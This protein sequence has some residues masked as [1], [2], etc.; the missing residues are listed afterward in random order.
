[1]EGGIVSQDGLTRRRLLQGGA[2]ALAVAVIDLHSWVP[3]FASSINSAPAYLQRSSYTPLLGQNF[4]ANIEGQAQTLKLLSISDV[5]RTGLVGAND[6]FVLELSG[7]LGKSIEQGIHTLK[8]PTLGTFNLFLT[9]VDQ[10]RSAQNYAIV[11]DRSVAIGDTEVP[12]PATTTVEDAQPNSLG[13]Q[14]SAHSLRPKPSAHHSVFHEIQVHRAGRD[15][16]ATI[17]FAPHAHVESLHAWLLH[18]DRPLAA[19]THHVDGS[20]AHLR[21]HPARR[22]AAGGYEIKLIATATEGIKYGTSSSFELA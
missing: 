10:P 1:M 3:A 14:N 20:H 17:T 4:A 15:V 8:H 19:A 22:P 16:A 5:E 9:P 18:D 6:A 12:A 2:G 13:P 21:L 11:I 7:A